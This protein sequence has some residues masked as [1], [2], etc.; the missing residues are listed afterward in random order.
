MEMRK[1]ILISSAFMILISLVAL[2]SVGGVT[3]HAVLERG[4]RPEIAKV[5]SD[6]FAV[7][8]ILMEQTA[9]GEWK[10]LEEKI[11]PYGYQLVISDGQQVVYPAQPAE[12]SRGSAELVLAQPWPQQVQAYS[13]DG[14]TAVGLSRDGYTMVAMHTAAPDSGGP[15]WVEDTLALFLI[16]GVIFIALML[17]FSQIFTRQMMGKLLRPMEELTAGARRIENGDLGTPVSYTGDGEF[18]TV[19]SAFNQMQQHLLEEREKNA[20]YEKARTDLVAGI[21]HDLRTPLTSVKGYLKG[22]QDGVANTPEKQAQYLEIAYQKACQME[23]LLQ[24]LFFFSKLEAG[25]FPLNRQHT[26]L[27]EFV[28]CFA[29][30]ARPEL[31]QKSVKLFVRCIFREHPVDLDLEQMTRVLTNL[32]ENAVKYGG[33]RPLEITISVYRSKDREY[34]FFSDNGNGV[35]DE[36]MPHL[37]ERFWRGDTARS[38]QDGEGSG[39]GLYIVKYIV[40]AHGGTVSAANHNGLQIEISLPCGKESEHAENSDRGR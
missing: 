18:A 28:R 15:K 4:Q 19:C 34:L 39:L 14:K 24:K 5:D 32:T 37:F 1:R 38:I 13:A 2:L 31:T 26:D 36:Q 22:M 35:T 27:G 23:A 11:A 10:A 12:P 7:G 21:S 25:S 33:K 40:E 17:L 29:S 30:E 6:G 8:E 3:I 20:V 9:P 16:V